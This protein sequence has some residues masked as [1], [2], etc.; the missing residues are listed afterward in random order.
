[1]SAKKTTKPKDKN[2]LEAVRVNISLTRGTHE[3]LKD[4]AD[5]QHLSSSAVITCLIRRKAEEVGLLSPSIN[6]ANYTYEDPDSADYPHPL[7]N[8]N[9]CSPSIPA[10][11]A[12]K[13]PFQEERRLRHQ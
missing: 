2:P 11:S 3:V 6:P 12:L 9:K 1:M 8:D 4:L 13:P 5:H 7:G 10:L